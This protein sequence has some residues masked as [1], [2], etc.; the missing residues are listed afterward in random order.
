MH[1]IGTSLFNESKS[2]LLTTGEKGNNWRARDLLSLL[3]R[4][5]MSSDIPE[6][7]RMSDFDVLSRKIH[8][9]KY[10]NRLSIYRNCYLPCCWT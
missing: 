1:R 4:A 3:I 2:T 6:S 8:A 7:Q 5:N 9:L 10:L